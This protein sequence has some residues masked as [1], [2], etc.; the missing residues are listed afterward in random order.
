MNKPA[1]KGTLLPWHQDR[2]NYLDR[3]PMI[4]VWTALDPATRANGCVEIIPGSHKLG[5]LNPEHGSGFL[6]AQSIE[7][8]APD[9]QIEYVELAAGEAVLLHNWLLHR[10]DKNSTEISRRAFS[11]CY[12]DAETVSQHQ[13]EQFS[14]V[15]GK[16]S[17]SRR[18]FASE[19]KRMVI[20]KVLAVVEPRCKTTCC[21]V[22]VLCAKSVTIKIKET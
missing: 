11:V 4:T 7:K 8:H 16:S 20:L 14:V 17:I 2:W 10:S 13:G 9:E 19:K 6:S 12:M 1:H 22:C 21:A 18:D 5:L 3:D 15:F